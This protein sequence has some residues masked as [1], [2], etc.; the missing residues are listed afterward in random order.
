M[1]IACRL[2]FS[3]TKYEDAELIFHWNTFNL[4]R[5]T[6]FWHGYF[7][8]LL[9]LISRFI[10]FYLFLRRYNFIGHGT[11]F[12]SP[13]QVNIPYFC[14]CAMSERNRL[15]TVLGK[16]YASLI[17]CLGTYIGAYTLA[18]FSF[19]PPILFFPQFKCGSF[20]LRPA[21]LALNIVSLMSF[22]ISRDQCLAF[23][24]IYSFAPLHLRKVMLLHLR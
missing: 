5:S 15:M 3:L 16:I 8:T 9:A 10:P 7:R 12:C 24:C 20:S 17:S 14:I 19:F 2:P 11:R 13:A 1:G 18:L 21:G 6:Y 4:L 22:M 23:R